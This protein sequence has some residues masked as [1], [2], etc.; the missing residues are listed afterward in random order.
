[1]DVKLRS[2]LKLKG[3][4]A[5]AKRQASDIL[6]KRGEIRGFLLDSTQQEMAREV[7]KSSAMTH[8]ILCSRRLGKSYML[9]TLAIEAA[10]RKPNQQLKYITGTQ[11]AARDIVLP[12]FRSIL[13][14]CPDDIRPE[15]RVHE[16]RWKFSNGSEIA[17]YGVDSS[18]GDDLRGQSCDG[19]WVDEAGFVDKL[20]ILVTEILAPMVIQRGARGVLSSTPPKDLAHPFTSFVAKAMKN[21]ALTKRTI[22]DC[23]RFTPKM[24]ELFAEE[25]GGVDSNVF[26]REYMCEM[27]ND[28]ENSVIPE[29]TEALEK[30]I[31]YDSYPDLGYIPDSYVALDPGYSDN[32]A[33]L[34]GF[35]DFKNATIVIQ[36]EF[37]EPGKNTQEIAAVIEG[38]ERE[39]WKGFKPLLRVSDTDLRLIEDLKVMHNLKFTK[40]AKDNKEAQINLLRILFTQKRI[41]IHSSCVNLLMQLRFAQWKVSASGVRDFKRSAELGHADAID[42]LIYLARNVKKNKNPIPDG[43]VDPYRL[44]S[45]EVGRSRL[46]KAARS[47]ASI[48]E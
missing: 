2:D 6:W 8:V 5:L 35:Y 9:V 42:A 15:W 38:T 19:F 36:R 43:W 46:K 3:A 44:N 17:L 33:I 40:T 37:V 1:M 18:G 39:L 21:K 25:A 27:I 29:F 20:D 22:Y 28:N 47:L 13:S 16:N 11:R 34:F 45:P 26:K 31:I 10:I 41:R 48:F 4:E 24:I 7:D 32:A 23:P 12:L 30:E 14:T